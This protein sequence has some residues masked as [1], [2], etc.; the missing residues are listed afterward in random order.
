VSHRV[1]NLMSYWILKQNGQIVSRTTVQ[2][3][4]DLEL[5]TDRLKAL[6]SL[7]TTEVNERLDDKNF[8]VLEGAMDQPRDWNDFALDTDP[9]FMEEMNKQIPYD[10][11][12]VPEQ[13]EYTPDTFDS[14]L[15]M[16]LSL[17][18]E[19]GEAPT[20]GKVTKRLRDKDGRPIG[21]ANDNP[22]LDT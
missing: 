17:S 5:T 9:K 11:D 12:F 1:G 18:Q 4:P 21:T 10:D 14:Y 6:C 16:E 15:Q 2:C 7:Y 19:P 3:V 20:Y 8:Q 22:L 13:D